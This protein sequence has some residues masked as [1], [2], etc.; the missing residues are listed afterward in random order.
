L[1]FSPSNNLPPSSI[2]DAQALDGP[3]PRLRLFAVYAEVFKAHPALSDLLR[4]WLVQQPKVKLNRLTF[5][6]L[7]NATVGRFMALCDERVTRLDLSHCVGI[8]DDVLLMIP[9]MPALTQL[10]LANCPRLSDDGVYSCVSSLS[11]LVS[12]DLAQ[13]IKLSD[14]CLTR[15][16]LPALQELNLS[17]CLSMTGHFL[18]QRGFPKVAGLIDC[19]WC[20][21][22]SHSQQV[23]TLRLDECHGIIKFNVVKIS[24]ETLPSLTHLSMA[25]LHVVTSQVI[26]TIMNHCS[27]LVRLDLRNTAVSDKLFRKQR[28]VTLARLLLNGSDL[29]DEGVT[30]LGLLPRLSSL[31]IKTCVH[32]SHVGLDAFVRVRRQPANLSS[33]APIV[34]PL[35]H[36][37]LTDIPALPESTLHSLICE[38]PSAPQSFV[39]LKLRGCNLSNATLLQLLTTAT[40]LRKLTLS[41]RQETDLPDA[42]AIAVRNLCS[43]HLES[44]AWGVRIMG[45]LCGPTLQS[46]KIRACPNLSYDA[47]SRISER[48][49]N[50]LKLHLVQLPSF[51][52]PDSDQQPPIKWGERM[53]HLVLQELPL[54]DAAFLW[55]RTVL[56]TL[57]ALSLRELSN[58]TDASWAIITSFGKN[59]R[60]LKIS[61]CPIRNNPNRLMMMPMLDLLY[62]PTN[63]NPPFQRGE[64]AVELNLLR[65]LRVD[66]QVCASEAL[67]TA[68]GHSRSLQKL[69]V[70][71]PTVVPKWWAN[72][73]DMPL[74]YSLQALQIDVHPELAFPWL[75]CFNNL[76]TIN[77]RDTAAK[78]I[79]STFPSVFPL[80]TFPVRSELKS[81]NSGINVASKGRQASLVRTLLSTSAGEMDG[82]SEP[83]DVMPPQSDWAL[84]TEAQLP[85][86][87]EIGKLLLKEYNYRLILLYR[88]NRS[89]LH[90]LLD[91]AHA[92]PEQVLAMK[93]MDLFSEGGVAQLEKRCSCIDV[94]I[95]G[96][97]PPVGVEELQV[98]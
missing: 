69:L 92:H 98:S 10:S 70:S 1:I 28:P 57:V 63:S 76:V 44:C 84:L 13:C 46:L 16:R 66:S 6:F 97:A 95:T 52:G 33:G 34:V 89:A 25:H 86:Q 24:N 74:R 81:R 65:T 83:S 58:I 4:A 22:P 91:F 87:L 79:M 21:P 5:D 85:L 94:A 20:S 96:F 77:L 51:G 50:L 68:L 3:P 48:C 75:R 23:H 71:P 54:T 15:L 47:F 27:Q 62:L 29:D 8:D 11:Q 61:S 49:S 93:L 67:F 55:F 12:L 43:L 2:D 18:G 14:A 9:R 53:R 41:G 45:E 26:A 78:A 32:V 56:P 35:T 19:S 73:A 39:S 90:E 40:S 60:F 36:L 42:S 82:S 7:G 88:G 17:R 30:A 38:L 59:L 37:D 31:N 80:L 72:F 64:T